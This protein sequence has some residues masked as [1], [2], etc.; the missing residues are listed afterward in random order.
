MNLSAHGC[1]RSDQA[2][3]HACKH[4]MPQWLVSVRDEQEFATAAK[5]RVDF[6]DLKEPRHGSLGPVEPEFWHDAV[7]L[8]ES[9]SSGSW[10]T[11]LSAALGEREQ[12]V[13][14]AA[15]LPGQ[16]SF[17]KA[18]PGGCQTPAAIRGLWRDVAGK[19]HDD[20]ELVAVAYA[21]A[22]SARCL[23]PET[24][25]WEADRAGLRRCLLDTFTKDGRS[26]LQHLG[27]QRLREF[28]QVAKRLGIW[29]ALAGSITR[30][31]VDVLKQ[32]EIRPDCWAVRG[33]VCDRD[34][35]GRLC[36]QRMQAWSERISGGRSCC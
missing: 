30:H 36:E 32:S 10:Q 14:I 28:C 33:D 19:L 27:H 11:K 20:I 1:I 24:V 13:R 5:F 35:T 4:L 31:D 18:G 7:R 16:F 22:T 12:A 9:R 6:I 3:P 2:D 25:L 34:R 29:W 17:A 8:M 23:E 21:D 15:A 26:S